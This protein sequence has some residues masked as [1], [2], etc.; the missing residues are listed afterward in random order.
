[1]KKYYL[2]KENGAYWFSE[3]RMKGRWK[4]GKQEAATFNYI[5][6]CIYT[7]SLNFYGIKSKLEEVEQ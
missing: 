3:G 1:M 6:G 7:Y 2:R 4:T 5:V